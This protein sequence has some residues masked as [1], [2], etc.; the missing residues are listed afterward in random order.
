M[1]KKHVFLSY[2]R[3][4]AD[5]VSRFHGELIEAGEPVWW[6]Q[7]ILPG[8][9]W[10]FEIRKA[11][12]DAYAVLL[13]LSKET[14]ERTTSGIYPEAL[15]AINMLRE[16]PPGDIF[17]IPVR[18]S[19][20]DIPMIEI[21]A[22]RTLDRLQFVDLF[23]DER[24]DAGFQKLIRALRAAPHHPPL[25]ASPQSTVAPLPTV[26]TPSQPAPAAPPSPGGAINLWQQKLAFF[27]EQEAITADPAQKFALKMQIEEAQQ[28]IRELTG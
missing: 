12:R 25:A 18:L 24:R 4:N 13:C 19:A 2:C 11:M 21:D 6:D 17:L 1:A 14:S 9:D 22:T 7:D 26:A 23:P 3:D 27:Q 5:E 20:C 15:D 10:K 16:Y 28:K 8:Q